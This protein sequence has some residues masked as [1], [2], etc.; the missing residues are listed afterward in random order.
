MARIPHEFAPIT[1]DKDIL[2]LCQKI[3]P[4]SEPVLVRILPWNKAHPQECYKNVERY[5]IE[6]GGQRLLGWRLLRWA[7]IMVE[8]EA[9]AVWQSPDGELI[10][11]TPYEQSEALFLY[12]P[13]LQFK[14]YSIPNRRMQ[15]TSSPLISE[16]INIKD[17]LENLQSKVKPGEPV[18]LSFETYHRLK[19]I[20]CTL[21]AD[22]TVNSPC[23]C[24]SGLKFKKC[25]GRF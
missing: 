19:E 6:Y 20:S 2:T 17:F 10:D 22:A 18:S 4:D 8:A 25:C 9:H 23:P 16:F 21:K 7:N 5:T 12:D 15:L 14:G 1:A 24:Q 3:T 11:I 13:T